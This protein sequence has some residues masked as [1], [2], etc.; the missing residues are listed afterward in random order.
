MQR[1]PARFARKRKK[2][3]NPAGV[4]LLF[5]FGSLRLPRAAPLVREQKSESQMSEL[6]NPS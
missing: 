6:L 1:S 2:Q 3:K 5:R 4:F